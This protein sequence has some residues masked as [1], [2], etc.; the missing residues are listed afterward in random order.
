MKC[1]S[2]ESVPANTFDP[3][4]LIA[5][6]L[7]PLS[8]LYLLIGF[9][10]GTVK[11]LLF[12]EVANIEL[13]LSH[14]ISIADLEIIPAGMSSCVGIASEEEVVLIAFDSDSHV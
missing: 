14:Q 9:K 2:F 10:A 6:L 8:S 13:H 5:I 12:S 7:F 3:I 11:I 1:L 4:N